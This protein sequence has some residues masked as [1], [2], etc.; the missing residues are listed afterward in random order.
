MDANLE[1]RQL[2][3]QLFMNREYNISHPTYDSELE[4]YNII[5]NGD[6]ETL[7]SLNLENVFFEN[8]RGILSK[9]P[10]R[11]ARYH[12]L[13]TVDRKSTRLNSSHTDSSRMPSS[14]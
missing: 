10:L 9:N 1:R 14:A 13:V 8:E 11:N 3:E 7:K 6:I 5:C 12:L 2:T 4:F